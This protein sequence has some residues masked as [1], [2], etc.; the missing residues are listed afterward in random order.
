M[1]SPAL[2]RPPRVTTACLSVGVGCLLT[3]S[4][5]AQALSD[6]GSLEV[7]E[8]VRSVL[9]DE[10]LS[11][12]GLEVDD[13]IGMLRWILMGV[14]AVSASGVI[15]AIFTARG[16]EASR[17]ILTVMCGMAALL[18]FILG[19]V[20]VLFAAIAIFCAVYL[21][22]PDAR[23]WFA[24]KNGRRPAPVS[25]SAPVS[26]PAAQTPADPFVPATGAPVAPGVGPMGHAEVGSTPRP[27]RPI[28]PNS[29][30]AAG[31]IALIM[32]SLV[33]VVCGLNA[34]AYLVDR[35]EYVR[36][37]T[38]SPLMKDTVDQLG[39]SPARLAELLFIGCSV[40]AAL[41][42]TAVAA[43]G[44]MVAGMTLGRIALISLTFV[45][46]PV[47]VLAFPVGWLWT[48]GGVVTLVLLQRGESRAWFASRSARS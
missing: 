15:F 48:A 28:R 25:A 22:T 5:A 14:A 29:V 43:T 27:A 19:V 2:M 32:S 20:G 36:L 38:E 40:A 46:L 18:F 11:S 23:E 12:A 47:S 24:I 34:L 7:Q 9:S 21:W 17:V 3:L 31:L 37:L 41:A 35:S 1:T 10:R 44:A 16:H 13:V 4:F 45:M 26:A 8:Q 30:I 39:M 6:W 42:L 33:V